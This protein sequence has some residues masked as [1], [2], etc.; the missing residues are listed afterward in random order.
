VILYYRVLVLV[1]RVL[2]QT[3]LSDTH[4]TRFH[5]LP[6]NSSM[7]KL[8]LD[9]HSTCEPKILCDLLVAL[10]NKLTSLNST[11]PTVT[12]SR[13]HSRSPPSISLNDYMDRLMKYCIGFQF[14]NLVEHSVLIV[15]LIYL[16]R[17]CQKNNTFAFNYL[18][19]HRYPLTY[20]SGLLSPA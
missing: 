2:G 18:T 16:D 11:L 15:V 1:F 17:F 20:N 5:A 3:Q 14:L 19:S 13:F 8:K 9:D 12:L 4:T 10:L 6:I 7:K